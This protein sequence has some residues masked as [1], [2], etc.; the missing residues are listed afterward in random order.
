MIYFLDQYG[1]KDVL[2]ATIWSIGVFL[3]GVTLPDWDHHAVQKKLKFI[4]WLEHITRHRGHFHSIIAVLVYGAVIFLFM[5]IFSVVYWYFPVIFGM[6]GYFSHLLEDQ[7][8]KWI[9]G[10]QTTSSIKIW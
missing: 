7:V 3:L 5:W 6:F 2:V 4:F 8:M 1:L 9:T 10:S